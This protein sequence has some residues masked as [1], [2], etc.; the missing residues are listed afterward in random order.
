VLVIMISASRSF[1]N[2]V[3]VMYSAKQ[4]LLQT[5]NLGK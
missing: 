1:Q 4:L 5:L 2:I 3:E